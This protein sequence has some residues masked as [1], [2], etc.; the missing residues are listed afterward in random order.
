[1]QLYATFD[2]YLEK[3]LK[4]QMVGML[5]LS[6]NTPVGASKIFSDGSLNLIQDRPALIDSITRSLYN[7]NPIRQ[8][9]FEQF[10]MDK[11]VQ[12]YNHRNGK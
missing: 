3:K 1:M 4:V 8:Y 11:I 10:S 12:D 9:T 6:V 2:Y 5:N 7:I